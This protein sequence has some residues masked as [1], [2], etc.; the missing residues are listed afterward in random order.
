MTLSVFDQLFPDLIPA[1]SLRNL[2]RPLTNVY[3]RRLCGPWCRRF[4]ALCSFLA[5]KKK[6][7]PKTKNPLQIPVQKNSTYMGPN[8]VGNGYQFRRAFCHVLSQHL[9]LSEQLSMSLSAACLI[10]L[11]L[12]GLLKRNGENG[13]P[14]C[15]GGKG[16]ATGS[17]GLLVMPAVS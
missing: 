8:R 11:D 15:R 4:S 12:S 10:L 2:Q 17:F 6:T 7:T 14:S 9:L 1:S 13:R 16:C 3:S 5:A